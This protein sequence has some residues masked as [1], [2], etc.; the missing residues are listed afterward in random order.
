MKI[1]RH[2]FFAWLLGNVL[3]K[4]Q[5]KTLKTRRKR[6]WNVRF[7]RWNF[8][9]EIW[10][11]IYF[12][13]FFRCNELI[14][15]S[16]W[17]LMT[18]W[19]TKWRLMLLKQQSSYQLQSGFKCCSWRKISFARSEFRR[20][21]ATRLVRRFLLEFL[22]GQCLL[23][24]DTIHDPK[25]GPCGNKQSPTKSQLRDKTGKKLISRDFLASDCR[26][27]LFDHESCESGSA[28]S[29]VPLSSIFDR[30]ELYIDWIRKLCSLKVSSNFSKRT[31][32]FAFFSS[33]T[34]NR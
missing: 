29:S 30:P 28:G 23:S 10:R 5:R 1:P 20:S 34:W 9:F 24:Q 13:A 16:A 11:K 22:E 32:T 7:T 12:G 17:K 8:R 15:Q 33:T 31:R 26:Q 4:F 6:T 25:P 21:P 18:C 3:S 19:W 2:R 27:Q 14:T